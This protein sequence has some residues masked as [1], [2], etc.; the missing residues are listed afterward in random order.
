MCIANEVA[1][2]ADGN[3]RQSVLLV[4]MGKTKTRSGNPEFYQIDNLA[5]AQEVV[6]RTLAHYGDTEIVIDFD[7]QTI[8]ACVPG[9]A[10]RG[11]AAGWMKR[12][13]ASEH[14]IQADVEWTQE[15]AQKLKDKKYRYL[16]PASRVEKGTNRVFQIINAG[17]TNTPNMD[18]VA[19]ASATASALAEP[20]NE[21]SH[22]KRNERMT[23]KVIASALGLAGDA[24]EAAI[25]A[26]IEANKGAVGVVTT[27]ASALG[28]DIADGNF[29]GIA[30]AVAAL[31]SAPQS[32]V[33][34]PS[35]FVPITTVAELTTQVASMQVTLDQ[36]KAEKLSTMIASA[37]HKLPPA[38]KAHAETIKDEV[39]LASFLAAIP[40]NGLGKP[41]LTPGASGEGAADADEIKIA[42]MMGVSA[43]E[44]KAARKLEEAV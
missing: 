44:F 5:H 8:L 3:V 32:T 12:V 2:S 27:T 38:M 10:G 22:E 31:K 42:S 16:S 30:N 13:Y 19:L 28:V 24:D 25:V 7:H 17:L 15:A 37:S 26:A 11:E 1:M 34:D 6:D 35:K 23:L 33:P 21:N 39:V 4:P 40:E 29:A 43:D 14:G 41:T 9:V 18:L 20:E 36:V